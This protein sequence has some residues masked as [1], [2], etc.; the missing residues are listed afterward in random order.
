M[1]TSI[2]PRLFVLLY[3][4]ISFSELLAAPA[5]RPD[6]VEQELLAPE[7]PSSSLVELKPSAK[8][9]IKYLRENGAS[10]PRIC[11]YSGRTGDVG[12]WRNMAKISSTL[13]C[14]WI[15]SLIALAQIPSSETTDWTDA[16][17]WSETSRA[18]ATIARNEAIVILGQTYK[19]DSVWSTVE[20]PT[21]RSSREKGLITKISQYTMEDAEGKL[22]AAIEIF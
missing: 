3:L 9:F 13:S 22:S 12:V 16:A 19:P 4:F 5:P 8:K 10:H 11:F 1:K 7:Y 17:E 21:L 2:V 20:L 15:S 14:E 18:L 6:A